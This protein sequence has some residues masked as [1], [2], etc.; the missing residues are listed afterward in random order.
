MTL[1]N[2]KLLEIAKQ[3]AQE[4]AEHF[5]SSD[6]PFRYDLS[7]IISVNDEGQQKIVELADALKQVMG[8]Y[9]IS[10]VFSLWQMAFTL[11]IERG[12]K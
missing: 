6:E 3:I 10:V 8:D 2:Q 7:G 1:N 9:K 12:M 4:S 11:I 5:K